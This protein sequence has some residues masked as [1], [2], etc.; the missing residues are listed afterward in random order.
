M[1]HYVRETAGGSAS[2]IAKAKEL[3]TLV[4]T[5]ADFDTIKAKALAS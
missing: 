3:S 2:E 5:Q 4:I 1:D